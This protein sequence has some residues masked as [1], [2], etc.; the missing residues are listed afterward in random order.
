[1][2]KAI[3][4]TESPQRTRLGK[5]LEEAILELAACLRGE[6]KLEEYEIATEPPGSGKSGPRS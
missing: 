4:N 6:I 1:M 2:V 5:D 3:P